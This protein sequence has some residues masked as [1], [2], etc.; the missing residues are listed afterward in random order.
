M[1]LSYGKSGHVTYRDTYTKHQR[2]EVNFEFTQNIQ[3]C[4]KLR[5]ERGQS[6]ASINIVTEKNDG[7]SVP[8]PTLAIPEP[9]VVVNAARFYLPRGIAACDER[10]I[11][12][13]VR[14]R[15]GN[16]DARIKDIVVNLGIATTRDFTGYIYM[17]K[18]LNVI[19][20]CIDRDAG[21]WAIR[22][23]DNEQVVFFTSPRG[24]YSVLTK[25]EWFK[26]RTP[27]RLENA[28]GWNVR[29]ITRH[30]IPDVIYCTQSLCEVG[31]SVEIP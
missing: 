7:W 13:E 3:G 15:F 19:I 28:H 16:D 2:G 9:N 31:Q 29:G 18:T 24:V 5:M 14:V 23:K 22:H 17:K 21:Q 25:T 30:N 6:P 12:L 1:A 8:D 26:G 27:I 10:V 4:W 20:S 11:P